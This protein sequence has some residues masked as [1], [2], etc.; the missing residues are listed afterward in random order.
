MIRNKKRCL[1]FVN[2]LYVAI[3][4]IHQ[5][6]KSCSHKDDDVEWSAKTVFTNE[7]KKK[8]STSGQYKETGNLMR[9]VI[10][11]IN[12]SEWAWFIAYINSFAWDWGRTSFRTVF[13]IEG[14]RNSLISLSYRIRIGGIS[15]DRFDVD[16]CCG[17]TQ[18]SGVAQHIPSIEFHIRV[19][20]IKIKS[21]NSQPGTA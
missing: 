15:D 17:T 20:G 9:Y 4:F 5:K 13:V 10:R 16:N 18:L 1:L 11:K 8:Y 12:M 14:A 6:L 3:Q 19:E 21:D 2:C 7:K